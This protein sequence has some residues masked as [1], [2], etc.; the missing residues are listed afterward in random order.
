MIMN[1]RVDAVGSW[2]PT[3]RSKHIPRRESILKMGDLIFFNFFTLSIGPVLVDL[4]DPGTNRR[5]IPTGFVHVQPSQ[6]IGHGLP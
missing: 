1:P 2:P 5:S 3:N 4:G 6:S